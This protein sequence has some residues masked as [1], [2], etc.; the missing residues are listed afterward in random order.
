MPF[1]YPLGTRNIVY[2]L[3][4]LRVVEQ[5]YLTYICYYPYYFYLVLQ[6][7]NSIYLFS[8]LR[9]LLTILHNA[10][11][12]EERIS[13]S[14]GSKEVS[15]GFR[16]LRADNNNIV[17]SR[18]IN[19][20]AE[21]TDYIYLIIAEVYSAIRINVQDLIGR[22]EQLDLTKALIQDYVY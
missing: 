14:G 8:G 12:G 1:F 22:E 10:F 15:V 21:S 7:S 16:T 11:V 18:Y 3:L 5:N 6:R 2:Y 17:E 20:N 9:N 4:V 13:S 19:I